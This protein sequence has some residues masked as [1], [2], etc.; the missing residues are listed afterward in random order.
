MQN[1]GSVVSPPLTVHECCDLYRIG[2]TKFY[3]L[4]NTGRGPKS[5]QIGRRRLVT[6][7]AAEEWLRTQES[8]GMT[9]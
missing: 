3:D 9:V 7:E 5:F 8:G 6:R 4:M 2:R 1:Q